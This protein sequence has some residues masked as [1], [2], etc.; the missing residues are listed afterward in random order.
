MKPPIYHNDIYSYIDCILYGQKIIIVSPTILT[1]L[2]FRPPQDNVYVAPAGGVRNG[3]QFIIKK[4]ADRKLTVGVYFI[5][6][7]IVSG[8][9]CLPFRMNLVLCTYFLVHI[10]EI[11]TRDYSKNMNPF[12][13]NF[14]N[15][16]LFVK[17]S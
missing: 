15:L 10:Y 16:A 12:P 7:I 6:H 8:L 3:H 5:V 17:W 1:D 14:F 11:A 2:I 4:G 13:K 9:S